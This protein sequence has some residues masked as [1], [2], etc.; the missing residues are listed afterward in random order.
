MPFVDDGSRGAVETVAMARGLAELGVREVHLTPHRFRFAGELSGLEIRRRTED[1]ARWVA[2]AG[3]D[4]RVVPGAEHW[5]GA[6]LLD[7]ATRGEDLVTFRAGGEECLLVE[8]PCEGPAAGV[9]AFGDLLLRRGIRPVLAHPE[10]I[11]A[12]WTDRARMDAWWDAGWR[13]Q[14]GLLSL[15]GRHGAAAH[16]A[17]RSLLGSGRCALVG[18][19]LH[20]PGDLPLLRRAHDEYRALAAGRAV[21]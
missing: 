21:A 4:L 17:A 15:V 9:R 16:Q 8:L 12:G 13:F 1:V 10:R 2:Q 11:A 18:S 3:I 6:R 20:R 19:D 14:L 7:A 5:Y